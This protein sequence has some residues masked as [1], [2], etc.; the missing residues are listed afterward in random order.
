VKHFY[1]EERGKRRLHK[2]PRAA[3][4]S[5]CKPWLEAEFEAVKPRV[6]VALGATA[7]VAVAGRKVAIQQERGR[8]QP[9]PS[10]AEFLV[11]VHPSFLLRIPERSQ[12]EEEYGRF[13][14]DLKHVAARL[15][16][17]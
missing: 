15:R 11:T 13:V 4:I 9:H 17:G 5:A 10:G 1:F 7:A 14:G 8:F 3:H 16:G 12:K 6:I 2:T